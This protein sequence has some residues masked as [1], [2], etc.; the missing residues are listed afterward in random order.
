MLRTGGD[1][2]TVVADVLGHGALALSPHRRG[3]HSLRPRHF[4]RMSY[5]LTHM[6][7]KAAYACNPDSS[8][9]QM[10]SENVLDV[11][12]CVC[13][14]EIAIHLNFCTFLQAPFE[15]KRAVMT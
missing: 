2:V 6:G 8:V 9:N 5:E 11:S 10:T 13:V 14:Y 3:D 1:I 7:T 15:K 12:W 4:I